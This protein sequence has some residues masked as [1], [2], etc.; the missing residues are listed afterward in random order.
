MSYWCDDGGIYRE[1]RRLDAQQRRA[2]LEAEAKLDHARRRVHILEE[3]G[4][5]FG[6]VPAEEAE[7]AACRAY[8]ARAARE[9]GAGAGA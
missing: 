1:Q 6:L 4:A 2:V 7:L 3:D 8:L 5:M 9:K